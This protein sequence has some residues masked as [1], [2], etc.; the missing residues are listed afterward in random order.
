[1]DAASDATL[2]AR[3]LASEQ[4]AWDALVERY[5]R[6]VYAIAARVYRLE[7]SDAEDVFQ[8]VFARVFERLDTLRDADALRPWI[9]QTTRRCAVDALRRS[10]R[11]TSRETSV[12]ELPDGA[13]EGLVQLDEAMTVHAALDR[14]SADCREILDRFFTRDE[15]YRTI[16]AQLDLPPGTI[17]SRIARC[18]ARLRDVLQPDAEPSGEESRPPARRVS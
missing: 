13:D 9:A 4:G 6:Y 2:V 15:S 1:V 7:P 8:E 16:G 17:A 11:E 3:C 5:A 18:L 10:G 14:L 12:D